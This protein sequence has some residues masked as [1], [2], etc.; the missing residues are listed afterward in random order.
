MS[1]VLTSTAVTVSTSFVNDLPR[2]ICHYRKKW[3]WIFD[4][5]FQSRMSE[6]RNIVCTLPFLICSDQWVSKVALDMI[7]KFTFMSELGDLIQYLKF[8]KFLS[9]IF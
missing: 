8:T 9:Q 4:R 7:R 5:P 2:C 6:W 1:V 3:Q